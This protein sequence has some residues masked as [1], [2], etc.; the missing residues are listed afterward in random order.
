MT[1]GLKIALGI[2]IPLVLIGGGVGAWYY[3]KLKFVTRKQF[4]ELVDTANRKG[5]DIFEDLP[6]YKL[7]EFYNNTKKNMTSNEVY[8]LTQLIEKG[9]KE[10]SDSD[11]KNWSIWMGKVAD[12]PPISMKG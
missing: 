1:K 10:W 7:D 9:E 2:G 6:S 4:N 11:K 5:S 12:I 8:G 3:F